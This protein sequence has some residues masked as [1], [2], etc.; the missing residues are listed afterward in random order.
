MRLINDEFSYAGSKASRTEL[1]GLA[2][3][4]YRD[5]EVECGDKDMFLYAPFQP[6]PSPSTAFYQGRL[7]DVGL[8]RLYAP[9][10]DVPDL[11]LRFADLGRNRRL[12]EGD[13]L[14]VMFEWITTYGVLGLDGVDYLEVPE[15]VEYREGRRESLLRFQEAVRRAARCVE[16]Y[17][18]ATAPD[19]PKAAVLERYG[20]SGS[21]LQAKREWA[22]IV[23]GDTVGEYVSAECY[24]MIYRHFTKETDESTRWDANETTGFEQG[25]GFRSLLGAMYLQMMLYMTLGGG[26]R[27]C[28]RP[29]CYKLVTF[30]GPRPPEDPGLTKG[31]RGKYRT[32]KDKVFCSKT[33]AQW[34]SDNYGKNSKKARLRREQRAD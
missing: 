27:R 30:E 8:K 31:A 28:K 22:L 29:D 6:P 15:Y 10:R 12:W 14:Q 7:Q 20:A 24:P 18:A 9:L 3:P 16:L 19:G 4:V 17:E 21:T 23:V 1:A 5:F 2:W 34:W 32:R 13:A 25:W 26:G 11:F 33:C